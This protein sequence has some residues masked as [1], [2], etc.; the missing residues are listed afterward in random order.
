VY[1]VTDS[2]KE[3]LRV[4]ASWGAAGWGTGTRVG[5]TLRCRGRKNAGLQREKTKHIVKPFQ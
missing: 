5:V 3:Q 2:E 4:M 1:V